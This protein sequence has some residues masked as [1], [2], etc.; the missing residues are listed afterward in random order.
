LEGYFKTQAT[1]MEPQHI[2][3]VE[4]LKVRVGLDSSANACSKPPLD[5]TC[6]FGRGV[7]GGGGIENQPHGKGAPS[8]SF[9]DVVRPAAPTSH[10]S[11]AYI[12]DIAIETPLLSL[13]S[14]AKPGIRM[15]AR[16]CAE[17]DLSKGLLDKIILK[18]GNKQHSQPL[19]YENTTFRCHHCK[20]PGHLQA[21]CPLGKKKF[22]QKKKNLP[23]N[24]SWSNSPLAQ[25]RTS[26]DK[27]IYSRSRNYD[28]QE[29]KEQQDEKMASGVKRG[30]VS[31]GSEKLDSDT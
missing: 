16:I 17:I 7:S 5:P 11:Q 24:G 27:T 29:R 6:G 31:D 8:S 12:V 20:T 15:Y 10:A 23:S 13:E 4:E 19:D 22:S 14:P 28:G 3:V 1:I 21:S 18:L 9:K 25:V 26:V 2:L 30:H